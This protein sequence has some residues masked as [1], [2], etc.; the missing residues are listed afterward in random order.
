MA[1]EKIK[2]KIETKKNI[3]VHNDLSNAA[4]Y[5]KTTM[6]RKLESGD[7][8]GIGFDGMACSIVLAFTFEAKINFLGH[9][10]IEGWKE[11]QRFDDKVDEVLG[12][13]GVKLD[14]S[15]RPYSSVQRLK[16][17]RDSIAHGK[18]V[19]IEHTDTVVVDAKEL[20]R[21]VDL[22]GEWEEACKEGP[23]FEAHADLDAVW[24]ELLE[25]SGL[26]VWETMTT[27]QGGITFIE[28][29][30]EK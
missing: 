7:R 26:T 10:L 2:A 21:N 23:V 12:N 17:F 16:A 27:G 20:D 1:L 30:V 18:P 15:K 29:I 8:E 24:N 9:K 3:Y 6:E 5:F 22:S 25:K 28:K 19:E 13:L 11:R 4:N 14:W